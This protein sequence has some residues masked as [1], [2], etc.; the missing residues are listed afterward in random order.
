MSHKKILTRTAK[1]LEK[2]ASHYSKKAKGATGIKKK[3][4]LIEK[5]EAKSAATE[6]KRRAKAAHEY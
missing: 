4:E 1:N 2:D 6:L 5:K 3:H